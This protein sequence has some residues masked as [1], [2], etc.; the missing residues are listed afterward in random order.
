MTGP[1]M[2]MVTIDTEEDDWGSYRLRGAS[3]ENI[4][5]LPELL[6]LWERFGVRPTYFVNYPP[7]ASREAS[8]VLHSLCEGGP[9]EMGAHCHPW[10]TPPLADGQDA[11]ESM[12]CRLSDDENHAKLAK[13]GILFQDL[14]ERRPRAFR[15]GRWGFGPS[16]GR[17]LHRLGYEA[18][19]S[20][21]PFMDWTDIGGPDYTHVPQHPYWFHPEAPLRPAENGPLVE[22][23][24]SIGFLRGRPG[25]SATLRADLE[26]SF[27]ARLKIVGILDTLGILARRWLSPENTGGADMIR[28][29]KT[30]TRSGLQVLDMT[31][32]SPSLLPGGTPF[33]RSEADKR[34]LLERIEGFLE[35]CREQGF[36]FCTASEVAR[37]V[38]DGEIACQERVSGG[39]YQNGSEKYVPSRQ[40]LP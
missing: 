20:V 1:V 14:F 22:I 19:F 8:R 28:L 33:V 39:V 15:A 5:L 2:V 9:C 7:L 18:D 34:R 4:R 37:A 6:P 30:L 36:Q 21:S 29:A 38:R 13:L 25:A 35:F 32:H 40:A 12:M 11:A 10:N 3:V 26:L 31:F 23:P 24:T 27:L 16:V 17:P